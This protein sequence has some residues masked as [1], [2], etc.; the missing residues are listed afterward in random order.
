MLRKLQKTRAV[1][2]ENKLAFL[3]IGLICLVLLFSILI[4]PQTRQANANIE[5]FIVNKMSECKSDGN[6]QCYKNIAHVFASQFGM[7]NI[8]DVFEKNENQPVFF[9]SCHTTLH[10]LGQEEYRMTKN[11]SQSLATGTP[12]CFA[13]FY[14]GVLEAH[15]IDNNLT[16]NSPRLISELPNLCGNE[17]KFLLKKT[18]YECLHGLGHA[19]MYASNSDLPKSLSFCDF[20]RNA[21]DKNW[22]YSGSFMENSTSSTNKDHPSQ[23]LKKDDIM[24]PCDILETR[25]LK[26]CYTLQSFYFAELVHYDWEQNYRLCKQVPLAYQDDCFGAIGQSQVGFTQDLGVMKDNC[27][28]IKEKTG[29]ASCFVGLIGALGERYDD[30]WSRVLTLCNQILSQPDEKENCYNMAILLSKNW[31][32]DHNDLNQFCNLIDSPKPKQN[33]LSKIN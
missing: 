31:I 12:I 30:G 29:R 4:K 33:C 16:G 24:Y 7:K 21:N 14:H 10:F 26:M 5:E 15:M 11:T 18:Y 17:T 3:T 2:R 27:Y 13:G 22:C 9:E 1:I 20:M 32:S 25:Y 19:L 6:V 8:L 23:Y 28:L